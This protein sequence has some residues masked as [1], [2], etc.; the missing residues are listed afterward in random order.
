MVDPLPSAFPNTGHETHHWQVSCSHLVASLVLFYDLYA[1]MRVL[2]WKACFTLTSES[3]VTRSG[4]VKEFNSW[5][6]GLCGVK[7]KRSCC[8]WDS[9]VLRDQAESMIETL[10]IRVWW[11]LRSHQACPTC[12]FNSSPDSKTRVLAKFLGVYLL[13]SEHGVDKQMPCLKGTIKETV[14]L[15]R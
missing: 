4:D 7:L 15:R 8:G 12:S 6:F 14:L 1:S 13:L 3:P 11:V 5:L 9:A 2:A 10:G